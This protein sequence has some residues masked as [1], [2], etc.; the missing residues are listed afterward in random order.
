[1]SE[2]SVNFSFNKGQ[3]INLAKFDGVSKEE[4]LNK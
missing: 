3:K 1:M 4:L 2:N